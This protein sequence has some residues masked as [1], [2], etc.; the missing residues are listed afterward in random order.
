MFVEGIDAI[1]NGISQYDTQESPR[2]QIRT[3]LSSRV[4]NF[5]PPWNESQENMDVGFFKAY[6]MV[7][8]EFEDAVSHYATSWLPALQLT[9]EALGHRFEFSETGEIMVLNQHFPWKDHL[10]TLETEQNVTPTVK[11]VVF[12]GDADWRVQ[13]VPESSG[14]FM[15]R[16]PLPEPWRGVRDEALSKLTGLDDSVFVHASGFI[17]GTKSYESALKMAKIA[18]SM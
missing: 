3:D 11:Y 7:K 14:S 13:A 4:S 17:G 8:A 1:D 15:S 16:K 9:R 5:H 12:G 10:M 18:L 6:A 2:Y